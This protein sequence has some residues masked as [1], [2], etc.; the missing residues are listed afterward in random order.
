MKAQW[1]N[2]V[3][4]ESDDTITIEGNSYFPP[5]SIK[6][7]FYSDSSTSTT[8]VWKGEASYY[9]ID[10]DGKTNNDAA[11]AYKSP[12]SSA[13][14]TVKKDFSGY[15]AFWRGVDVS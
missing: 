11:F 12:K 2:K 9:N 13:I 15:V 6:K 14:D 4:A 1:N 5:D 8:C 7:E 10:V 3:I